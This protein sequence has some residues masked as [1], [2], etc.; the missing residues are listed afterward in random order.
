MISPQFLLTSLIVVLVPGTGV[1]YTINTGLVLKWRASLAAAVG[2]TLGIV[3]HILASILGLSALLNMSAQ[4]FSVLKIAGS[5]YLLC[6]AWNMWRETGTVDINKKNMETGAI[7]IA[8]KAIAINL[9]NPK[10]TIFFFAFLPLFVSKNSASPT[11]EMIALS[12]VFMG[13][14]FIIF[15]LYGI[16]AS[17][18]SGY[19]MNSSKAVRRFQQVFAAILAVFA[20]KLAL[21]EK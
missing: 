20:V 12:A 15:A 5:L 16:L 1:V 6:L 17:V 11:T 18:I 19:L 13:I 8:A 10:L 2:C 9:L 3:P 14:T 4:A 7:Q 21:S